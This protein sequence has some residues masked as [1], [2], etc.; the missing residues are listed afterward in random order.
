MKQLNYAGTAVLLLLMTVGL[1]QGCNTGS[2]DS[3]MSS[4]LSGTWAV[5][6]TDS[7][8]TTEGANPDYQGICECN[9]NV[10][11]VAQD[12]RLDIWDVQQHGPQI[13]IYNDVDKTLVAE[14]LYENDLLTV[15]SVQRD[16]SVTASVSGDGCCFDGDDSNGLNRHGIKWADDDQG[17]NTGWTAW[18]TDLIDELE[19]NASIV[20]T[21]KGQIEYQLLGDDGPVLLLFHGGQGGYDEIYAAMPGLIGKGF[22]ILTWSRP[23]YLRTPLESGRSPAEQAD[24]AAA[25]LDAL[26]I[27][28]V[29]IFGLSAGGPPL[30]EFALRYPHRAWA[31]I[32]ISSVSQTYAPKGDD[33]A[34]AT[35]MSL[36][37]KEGGMWVFNA[38]FEYAFEASTRLL[39][40]SNSTL[41]ERNFNV[42][43]DHVMAD[44]ER[45][46]L[47]W[48][49]M[50]SFGPSLS[51]AAGTANDL[52]FDAELGLMPLGD[53]TS[54]TL[55]VHGTNDGDVDPVHAQYAHGAVPDSEMYWVSDGTH[56]LMLA[57][58]SENMVTRILDFFNTHRPE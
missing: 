46:A 8:V 49:V 34:V 13:K 38:M 56:F 29:G 11:S 1:I 27:D 37:V 42:W 15:S 14:G 41:D 58:E 26:E 47:M 21:T 24:A 35:I 6:I 2:N 28:R 53:V 17:C 54:P 40:A 31:L 9:L 19:T 39:L 50:R 12:I 7:A 36:F 5:M 44:P 30:Y 4:G 20:Q 32:P 52:D 10:R 16:W 22:R 51:R 25:L 48:T 33:P 3:M 57:D 43:I 55:I 18:E 45:K 23:G